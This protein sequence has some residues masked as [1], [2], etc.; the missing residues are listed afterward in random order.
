MKVTEI[1]ARYALEASYRSFPR[2]VVHQAKRCFLDL[3]GVAL[4][5]S[6]QPLAKILLRPSGNSEEIPRPRSGATG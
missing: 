5:G 4:G 6:R 3:I 2:E 1:L